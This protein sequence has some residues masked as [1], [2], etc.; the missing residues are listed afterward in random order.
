MSFN[1]SDS[2]NKYASSLHGEKENVLVGLASFI[3]ATGKVANISQNSDFPVALACLT[4][5]SKNIE[6]AGSE[7]MTKRTF[8]CR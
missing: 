1:F 6:A 8:N 5:L 2:K 7:L 4:E 3:T